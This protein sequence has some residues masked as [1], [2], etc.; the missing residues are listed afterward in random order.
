MPGEPESIGPGSDMEANLLLPLLCLCSE[1]QVA[2]PH[3]AVHHP[4]PKLAP[5]EA[6]PALEIEASYIA[7]VIGNARGGKK[8]GSRYLDNGYVAAALDLERLGGWR[9]GKATISALY[10]N[11]ASLGDLVGDDHGASN[12]ETGV[13]AV[14]LYEAWV[15]QRVGSASFRVGLYDLNSEFDALESSALFVGSSHGI[16]TDIGQTGRNGPSIFPATSLALRADVEFKPGFLI[17]AAVLDAVPGDPGHPARTAVLL[18]KEDGALL[19]GEADMRIGDVRI[20]LGHW[21]YTAHFDRYDGAVGRGNAGVYLRG[22]AT[23]WRQAEER[24]SAFFRLGT[25]NGDFNKMDRFASVGLHLA[26]PFSARP[27]DAF[28][29]AVSTGMT[30]GEYR[31]E[32]PSS[33]AETVVE[34]TYLFRLTPWVA[35]Q[36]SAQWIFSPGAD[37]I[38]KDA[39][40][41]GMRV[42]FQFSWGS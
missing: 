26:A 3:P 32:T 36:P 1:A 33:R 39:L 6:S 19:I 21:R 4:E 7:E 31:L 15:E 28:G 42:A 12:I 30:S 37:P 38:A 10:N 41:L 2:P 35:L 8:R 20:L 16:G 22:E 29:V 5:A 18:R 40:V 14:R 34:A 11:G 9:G 17:R 27:D 13:Q 24:L 23:L 25:A